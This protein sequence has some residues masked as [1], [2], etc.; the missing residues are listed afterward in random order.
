MQKA[1]FF[2]D[3]FKQGI[4]GNITSGYILSLT[5]P[6]LDDVNRKSDPFL[7]EMISYSGV[8]A[9]IPVEGGVKFQAQG[10]KMF[11]MLEPTTYSEKHVDPTYRSNNT[12]GF[13]P[14]RFNECDTF[15]T[16]DNRYTVRMPNVPHNCYDSFTVSFPAKG[17][18]CIIYFIFDKDIQGKVIPFIEENFMTILKKSVNL[19]DIDSNHIAKKFADVIKKLHIFA[20]ELKK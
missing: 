14:F 8:K 12:T 1:I 15:L 11:C 6:N 16:K 17:D 10:S 7:F 2:E 5:S 4:L 3:A 19:R 18:L 13:M 20:G 9:V